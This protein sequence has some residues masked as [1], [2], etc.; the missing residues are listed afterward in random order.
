MVVELYPGGL[1]AEGWKR[2]EYYDFS[3]LDLVRIPGISDL[4]SLRGLRRFS[5]V[6]RRDQQFDNPEKAARWNRNAAR[7]T[8]LLTSVTSQP[9][10]FKQSDQR[11]TSEENE[12]R[13]QTS[14]NPTLFKRTHIDPAPDKALSIYEIPATETEFAKLLFSRPK[15]LFALL[16]NFKVRIGK[17]DRLRDSMHPIRPQ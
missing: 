8:S 16:Q 13:A 6:L 10:K 1:E 14:F 11:E 2:A 5:V 9:R 3:D 17:L 7:L 4:L 15:A 12:I